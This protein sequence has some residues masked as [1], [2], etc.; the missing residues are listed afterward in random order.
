MCDV[1]LDFSA[2]RFPDFPLL[3]NETAEAYLERL[4]WERAKERYGEISGEVE[5]QLTYELELIKKLGLSGYFLTVWDLMEYCRKNGI[6]AQGRGSAANSIVAY[7]LGITRVDPI[8]NKLFVG[9]F[10][11]EEMSSL[12]D[13]DIDVSTNHREQVIQYIY[14]KYGE[15]HVAMVCTFVTF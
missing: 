10:I 5:D 13:I 3:D 1:S 6:P 12:P 8:R 11:N 7:M 4:C 9:R 2:Y 15:E 14:Q